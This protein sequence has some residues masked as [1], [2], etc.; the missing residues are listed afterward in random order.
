MHRIGVLAELP[1]P[2]WLVRDG[3]MLY[4]MLENT[5]EIATLVLTGSHGSLLA[6]LLAKVPSAGKGPTHAALAI[7]ADGHRHL[8]VANYAD[9]VIGIHPIDT[10]GRALA[11]TQA[12]RGEGHGPLPAQQGPH[13]HWVLP[14]PDGRVLTTDL[15]SDRVYVH[16]WRHNELVRVGAVTL[17]PG[18]G[19]RDL[20]LLPGA[21]G[22]WRVAV[23]GEWGNTVTLLSDQSEASGHGTDDH[24]DERADGF[25][26]VQTVDL[27]AD[28]KDQAASLAFVPD[29]VLKG[30][31]GEHT[32]QVTTHHTGVAYVG[33]RGSNRIVA[34]RWDGQ[35]LQRGGSAGTAAWMGHGI[36]VGGGRPRQIVTVGRLLVAADET[37]DALA[38]FTLS[39]DGEPK[40]AGRV[41]A[42]SPTVVLAVSP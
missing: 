6:T 33:L 23:V 15:G 11:A 41:P 31:F 8:V 19:P 9:G 14:L 10:A 18:T 26:T 37:G 20:H 35:R 16:R 4:A 24:T 36:P 17:A 39:H 12:L 40:V 3:R 42:G 27:A 1:S 30:V 22:I 29:E 5:D 7:D 13:A 25:H 21:D 2:S 38:M 34:L 28:R 32:S